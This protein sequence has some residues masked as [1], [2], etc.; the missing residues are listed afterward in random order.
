M[1][2]NEVINQ[3]SAEHHT[4]FF[5]SSAL[6]WAENLSGVLF[7][8]FLLH[9]LLT[10]WKKILLTSQRVIFN[11]SFMSSD[12]EQFQGRLKLRAHV[13][14]RSFVNFFCTSISFLNQHNA[15]SSPGNHG[16]S[17]NEAADECAKKAVVRLGDLSLSKQS[18]LTSWGEDQSKYL[19]AA[20]GLICR[21]RSVHYSLYPQNVG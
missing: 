4:R 6:F 2:F 14:P 17:G 21:I 1:K 10:K 5:K 15:I 3:C 13:I 12:R 18:A 11:R 9:D 20:D 8:Y 16:V 7:F 19:L